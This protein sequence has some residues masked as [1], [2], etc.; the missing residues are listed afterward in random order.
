MK[1]SITLLIIG[2]FIYSM[3]NAQYKINKTKFDF[4]TY[5]YQHGD[6]NNPSAMVIASAIIPGLG[7]IITGETGRGL[8]FLGGSIG[9][10]ILA[11]L[12]LQ[13]AD[14]D[15]GPRLLTYSS[16]GMLTLW[17][18]SMADASHVAKVNN[19]AWR[20]RNKSVL[21]LEFLPN[22][23]TFNYGGSDKITTGISLKINF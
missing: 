16:I 2:L 1:K 23:S 4:R 11:G 17:I 8:A 7:Q 6:P 12:V 22:I 5:H 20:D 19:L 14:R 13:Y 10:T 15:N 3:A 18:W 9:C 21:K